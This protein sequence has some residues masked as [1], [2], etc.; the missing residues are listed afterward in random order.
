MHLQ[1]IHHPS[2]CID[3]WHPTASTLCLLSLPCKT[4]AGSNT[5]KQG[6]KFGT[7]VLT[8]LLR[9]GSS[10]NSVFQVMLQHSGS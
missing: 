8:D 1:L 3:K 10:E 9:N 5:G 4:S 2:M 6:L 7:I